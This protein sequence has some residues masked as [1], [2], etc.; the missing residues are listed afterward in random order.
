[1]NEEIEH[2]RDN[3]YMSEHY[4]LS[5]SNLLYTLELIETYKVLKAKKPLKTKWWQKEYIKN[6]S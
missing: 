5:V 1:M 3:F 6:N 4:R 2:F